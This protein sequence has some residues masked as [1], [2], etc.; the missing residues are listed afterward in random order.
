MSQQ[1]YADD[2]TSPVHS[3]AAA[4]GSPDRSRWLS[5]I[6]PLLLFLAVVLAT[7]MKYRA[8]IPGDGNGEIPLVFAAVLPIFLSLLTPMI[9]IVQ[10]ATRRRQLN[11]LTNLRPFRVSR[12][13]YFRIAVATV[14][15]TRTGAVDV[16]FEAP[17]FG[18]F[19]IV[20]TGFVAFL[21]G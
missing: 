7:A 19:V 1:T 4:S 14:D 6:L 12:S 17:L 11:R 3:Q 18:Y 16:D 8:V 9:R 2:D 13:T 5:R 21:I 10:N 15:G 20:F